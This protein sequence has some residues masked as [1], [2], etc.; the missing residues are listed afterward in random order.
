MAR[1]KG[2]AEEGK[3]IRK[4][5]LSEN[6]HEDEAC[7]LQ[8]ITRQH[9]KKTCIFHPKIKERARDGSY[10]KTMGMADISIFVAILQIVVRRD[11]RQFVDLPRRLPYAYQKLYIGSRM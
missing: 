10:D 4:V 11:K 2:E 9:W 3:G 1:T 6:K 8:I 5:R 7:I